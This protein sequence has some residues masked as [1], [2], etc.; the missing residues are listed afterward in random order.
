[1]MVAGLLLSPAVA[2]GSVHLVLQ[3]FL[4]TDPMN[5]PCP[6]PNTVTM[7]TVNAGDQVTYCYVVTNSY[8]STSEPITFSTNSLMDTQF[9][10]LT[11]S[12]KNESGTTVGGSFDLQG[13]INPGPCNSAAPTEPSHFAYVEVTK[14]ITHDTTNS[15]TWDTSSGTRPCVINEPPCGCTGCPDCCD[16]DHRTN[17]PST[18]TTD[19]AT[20]NE[21][22]VSINTPTNTPTATPT[23]TP[24]STATETPTDTPSP[25]A[26]PT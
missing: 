4:I 19:S 9:G 6:T 18:P 16:Q 2:I 20:S 23:A 15:A 5:A 11:A 3:K 24:T 22:L 26:T 8:G 14:T 17:C 10:D 1:W 21:V 7:L 12:I 13:G 25:T